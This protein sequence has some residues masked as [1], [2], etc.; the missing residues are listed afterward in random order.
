VATNKKMV[1][2][3]R[4]ELPTW[5]QKGL[6]DAD[7]ADGLRNY[8]AENQEPNRSI[9][10]VVCGVLGAALIGLGIILL[11]AHNWDAMTRPQR[12]LTAY[13]PLL[14]GI[15]LTG[16]SIWNRP[17]SAAWCEASSV[18]LMASVGASI[19]LV[20]QTYHIMSDMAGF[21]LIWMLLTG[22]LAYLARAR[23]VAALYW[24]GLLFFAGYARDKAGINAMLYW[25]LAAAML[26]RLW[27]EHRENPGGPWELFLSWTLALTLCIIPPV[28]LAGAFHHAWILVYPSIFAIFYVA[29]RWQ[30]REQGFWHEPFRA[31]STVGVVILALTFT[32]KY[33]WR[34]LTWRY[35]D[36]SEYHWMLTVQDYTLS[37]G[38][39]ALALALVVL[40]VVKRRFDLLP[41]GILPALALTGFALSATKCPI[42]I[43]TLGFNLYLLTLAL[44]TLGRGIQRQQ[45]S[46]MNGGLGILALL[47]FTRFLD[48]DL[49]I[50]MRGIVFILLGAGFLITNVV[51]LRRREAVR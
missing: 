39:T 26:P 32:S 35:S 36:Y 14:A 49:P 22:P 40:N 25:P 13:L 24:I 6:V 41:F 18:F 48:S 9:A 15:G 21:L 46:R 45:L 27:M 17:R 1:E 20:S 34:D 19:A 44:W 30:N 8:Y 42:G 28:L 10:L 23:V 31:V 51:M 4:G 12:A 3:L 16:W 29:A 37:F 5:E 2:W 7:T 47:I 38:L 11:V 33:C 50:V 43:I